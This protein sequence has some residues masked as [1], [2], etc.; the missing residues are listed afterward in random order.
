MLPIHWIDRIFQK[1]AIAYGRDFLRKWEGIPEDE[2]K[3]DWAH[4]LAGFQERPEAIM[5]A[6]Q[7][8]PDDKPPTAMEFRALCRTAPRTER[9]SLPEP[10]VDRA[11]LAQVTQQVKE[12]VAKPKDFLDWA[13][14][15]RSQYALN[16]IHRCV[17]E[18]DSRFVEILAD[19]KRDG[20]ADGVV[21]KKRWNGY[22][23]DAA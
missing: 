12:I 6:L 3:E 22:G 5:H 10:P 18:K 7:N 15:P 19:L 23:W 20:I 8:L 14:H 16:L 17:A 9:P 1:L 13:R 2:V 21:L 4:T 11:K